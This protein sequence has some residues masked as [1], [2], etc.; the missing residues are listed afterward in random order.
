MSNLCSRVFFLLLIGGFGS[1]IFESLGGGFGLSSLVEIETAVLCADWDQKLSRVQVLDESTS[2]GTTD[3]EFFAKN[4]SGDTE[5]F[6][7]LLKHLFKISLLEEHSVIKLFLNLDLSPTLL[8]SFSFSCC[9]LFGHLGALGLPFSRVFRA[10]L[11]F[12][13]LFK[14]QLSISSLSINL[15][16]LKQSKQILPLPSIQVVKDLFVRA[17]TYH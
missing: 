4:G 5:N 11:C 14:T 2:N 13:S 7:N 1:F 9:L 15:F 10:D 12:F 6:W 3:L 17:K 8:L 16:I